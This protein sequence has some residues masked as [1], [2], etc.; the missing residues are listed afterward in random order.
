M[1]TRSRKSTDKPLDLEPIVSLHLDRLS[2]KTLNDAVL[3][4]LTS[5]DISKA[6]LY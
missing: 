2:P 3:T 4:G 5:L 6:V 1:A